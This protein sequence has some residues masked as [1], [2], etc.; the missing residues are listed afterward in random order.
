MEIFPG[1]HLSQYLELGVGS[2]VFVEVLLL[3]FSFFFLNSVLHF[4][5]TVCT[6]V[7]LDF[8][9]GLGGH[10]H[11]ASY[12]FIIDVGVGG[13]CHDICVAVRGQPKDSP[14]TMWGLRLGGQ[15]FYL[16]C[17]HIYGTITDIYG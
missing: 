5:I 14:P 7:G 4:H 13:K 6:P 17:H 15:H 11:W 3:F 2:S 1:F 9:S 8:S 16:L 12:L 10:F